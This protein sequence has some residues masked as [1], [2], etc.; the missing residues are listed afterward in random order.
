M[1]TLNPQILYFDLCKKFYNK[2]VRNKDMVFSFFYDDVGFPA[3]TEAVQKDYPPDGRFYNLLKFRFI[4]FKRKPN[5]TIMLTDHNISSTLSISNTPL[6]RAIFLIEGLIELVKNG[7]FKE[8]QVGARLKEI[9]KDFEINFFLGIPI[10]E[11]LCIQKSGKT[12]RANQSHHRK[13]FKK[14]ISQIPIKTFTIA[15]LNKLVDFKNVDDLSIELCE[16]GLESIGKA[17]NF[18][19]DT[20][21]N[22]HSLLFL[23]FLYYLKASIYFNEALSLDVKFAIAKYNYAYT[24]KRLGKLDVALDHLQELKNWEFDSVED[25]SRV[26]ES[27]GDIYLINKNYTKAEQYFKKAHDLTPKDPEI[28]FNLLKVY[29]ENK[30]ELKIEETLDL[31]ITINQQKQISKQL[32]KY[33]NNLLDSIIST[34]SKNIAQKSLT[35]KNKF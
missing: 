2:N 16:L 17:R 24:L 28:T 6:E 15:S 12:T 23:C 19:S 4:D 3:I 22:D 33:W 21:K 9:A 30:N 29:L 18:E 31:I 25:E 1:A 8:Q 10:D 11:I 13:N 26:L 34:Y 32:I 5:M 35:I 20:M 14:K 27:I 7:E